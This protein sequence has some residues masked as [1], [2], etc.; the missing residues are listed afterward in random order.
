MNDFVFNVAAFVREPPGTS[1]RY[2]VLAPPEALNVAELATPVAGQVRLVRLSG[3]IHASGE[4][5]ASIEQPCARCL[6][7]ARQTLRFEAD[8]EFLIDPDG[9][10]TEEAS[11]EAVWPLDDQHNLDLTPFLAEGLISALPL[12]PVCRPECPGLESSEAPAEA[13]IDPRWSRLAELRATM[14]PDMPGT[15]G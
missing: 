12:M 8:G 11:L 15:K 9:T 2:D 13:A 1:R 6:E 3:A 10:A 7:P 5:E 4:F 14:F